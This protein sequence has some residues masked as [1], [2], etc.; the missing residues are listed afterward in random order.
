MKKSLTV[1]LFALTFNAFAQIS[2]KG[3]I[4]YYPF[5]GN[6]NDYSGN[7]YNGTVHGASLTKDRFGSKKSA[8]LFDGEK[9]YIDLS[10][11]VPSLNIKEPATISFWIKSESDAPQALISIS[12][13]TN[14]VYGISSLFV[15]NFTTSTLA[16]ELISFANRRDQTDDYIT[17]YTTTNRSIL[18]DN[19]WHFL[20][21]IFNDEVTRIFLDRLELPLTD[22]KTNNGHFGE[23]PNANKILIGTRYSNGYGAFFNGSLD[24][25]RIYNRALDISEISTLFYEN[26]A[27]FQSITDTGSLIITTDSVDMNPELF[28]YAIKIYPNKEKDHI[29]IDSDE[30][31]FGYK[32]KILN[33]LNKVVYNQIIKHSQYLVDLNS[34]SGKGKY[35]VQIF[36]PKGNLFD[37]KKIVLQ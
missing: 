6:A 5:S 2:N 4:V 3:L 18:L 34:W 21:I 16:D 33:T 1:L 37:V 29:Y 8:Y 28:T 9:D 11:F 36:D 14:K 23:I 26:V 30:N 15:G 22:Y 24:E 10:E 17:G 31:F 12:D 27:A 20:V 25:L 19:N 32:I 35:F 7:A 13:S